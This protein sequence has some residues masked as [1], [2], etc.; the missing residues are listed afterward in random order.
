MSYQEMKHKRLIC[1]W[2]STN[3]EVYLDMIRVLSGGQK[4]D[5]L[6]V[7]LWYCFRNFYILLCIIWLCDWPIIAIMPCH[8]VW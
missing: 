2:T 8:G 5:I 1:I 7:G 3:V 4:V 6:E